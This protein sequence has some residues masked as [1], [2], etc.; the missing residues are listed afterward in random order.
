MQK[1]NPLIQTF[2]Q[3]K[4][5]EKVFEILVKEYQQDLYWHLRKILVSHDSTNDCLQNTFVK[6]WQNLS[7][8]K[9][10]SAIY[11]WMY[12]IATNEALSHLKKE[13]KHLSNNLEIELE[14]DVYFN[15][16]EFEK[17]FALAL[18]TLPEKQRIVFQLKYFDEMKYDEMSEVLETSVGALKASYHHAVG[19]LKKFVQEINL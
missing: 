15:G 19:K 3:S 4:K 1:E 13:K 8:F 12:R 14:S 18:E 5:W 11:T 16:D 2:L 6:I 10:N 17:H 7:K 9:G